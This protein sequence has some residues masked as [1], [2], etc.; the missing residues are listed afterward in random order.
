MVDVQ[1]RAFGAINP[2][3]AVLHD[4]LALSAD[5]T[6]VLLPALQGGVLLPAQGIVVF[7]VQAQLVSLLS[8]VPLQSL[9]MV[10]VQSRA[11]GAT[12]GEHAP[13]AVLVLSADRTQVL[14]P[15]LQGGVLFPGQAMVVF[16]VQV[17]LV[18]LLSTV[19][20]QSLSMVEVQSRAFGATPGEH[21]PHAVLVLSADRTQVLVPAAQGAVLF[22]GQTIV[23]FAGQAQVESMLSGVPLQSLSLVDV[24]SRA[25]AFVAPTQVPHAELAQV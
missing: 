18:S 8:A 11:F 14:V 12:P 23:V 25:W 16:A 22:P 3:H 6:H 2:A 21:A 7:G 10:E 17:Q 20:L 5:R 13:H 9:S 19:P 24:Q 15:T 1:S 4:V